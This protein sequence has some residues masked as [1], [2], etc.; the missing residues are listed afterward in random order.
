M[1]ILLISII[2]FCISFIFLQSK[3]DY[4]TDYSIINKILVNPEK[5]SEIFE[6]STIIDV[7]NFIDDVW[8]LE[9]PIKENIKL[10]NQDGYYIKIDT[11]SNYLEI[12]AKRSYQDHEIKLVSKKDER[13]FLIF[14][15]FNYNGKR[16]LFSI[17][18]Y[19]DQPDLFLNE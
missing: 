18:H 1:K 10:L 12:E 15:F 11:V 19:E 2:V 8:Y 14:T 3:D 17:L 9:G 6:D 13:I 7:A 16:K 4:S 5:I